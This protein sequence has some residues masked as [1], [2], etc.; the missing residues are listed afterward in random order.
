[1][2][3]LILLLG[4][5]ALGLLLPL[6]GPAHAQ[7]ATGC[8]SSSACE[9]T[10]KSSCSTG[11]GSVGDTEWCSCSDTKCGTKP[12]PRAS[13]DWPRDH[14][15]GNPGPQPPL[16]AALVADCHGNVFDILISVGSDERSVFL[17]LPLIRVRNPHRGPEG[18]LAARE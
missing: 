4:T 11:C 6:G 5:A 16:S 12:L 3:K 17:D 14:L 10:N 2:R 18:R 7:C 1:M 9:G 8:S 13:L 15:A